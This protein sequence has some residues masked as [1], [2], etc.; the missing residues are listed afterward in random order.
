MEPIRMRIVDAARYGIAHAAQ[1]HYTEDMRRDD[2]LAQLSKEDPP[3]FP[4]PLWT[5]CSGFATLCYYLAGAPDPNGLH[6]QKV[7]YTGTMLDTGK[8]VQVP[9]PGDLIVYGPG[10]GHHVVI[11]L[12]TWRGAWRVAS[13]GNEYGPNLVLQH[14]EE[15]AQPAP[16]TILSYLPR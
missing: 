16:R 9:E 5:D 6:Y 12:D 13:H 1:I 11:Y 2:W 7:G 8:K 4:L 15:M 3:Q 14:R 10:T